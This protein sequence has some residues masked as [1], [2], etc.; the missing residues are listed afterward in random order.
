MDSPSSSVPHTQ[1]W[2]GYGDMSFLTS[3]ICSFNSR[4][5]VLGAV[6]RSKSDLKP[7][8][9]HMTVPQKFRRNSKFPGILVLHYSDLLRSDIQIG[10]GFKYTR[11]LRTILELI[12]AAATERT[13]IPQALQRAVER[14]LVTRQHFV[15]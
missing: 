3:S 8:K 15:A 2:R 5:P 7:A 1:A 12:E 11:P 4:T 13:F 6:S 9:L 14:G 10:Q